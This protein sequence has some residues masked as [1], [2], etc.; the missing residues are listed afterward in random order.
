MAW[1]VT[2]IVLGLIVL[3]NCSNNY[4]GAANDTYKSELKSYSKNHMS[5]YIKHLENNIIH[6]TY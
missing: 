2:L 5:P 3:A 4:N 6:L 1:L